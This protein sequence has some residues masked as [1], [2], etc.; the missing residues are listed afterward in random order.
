MMTAPLLISHSIVNTNFFILPYYL[1]GGSYFDRYKL[2]LR[3][4]I[5]QIFLFTNDID[6]F[7]WSVLLSI[8]RQWNV[9]FIEFLFHMGCHPSRGGT[10]GY[11]IWCENATRY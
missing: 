6:I 2:L 4:S 1:M 9:I 3:D 8:Y 10:G 7:K 11:F 5:D